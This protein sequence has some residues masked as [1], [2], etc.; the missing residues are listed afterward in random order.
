MDHLISILKKTETLR[1]RH[2]SSETP[3]VRKAQLQPSTC[4]PATGF[5]HLVGI[6]RI[7]SGVLKCLSTY[8]PESYFR[9]RQHQGQSGR[10]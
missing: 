6:L 2:A 8:L 10:V 4:P 5:V 3:T 1:V 7:K 9:N